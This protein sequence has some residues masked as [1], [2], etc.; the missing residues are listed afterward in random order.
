MKNPNK[1]LEAFLLIMALKDRGGSISHAIAKCIEEKHE[2]V[3]LE[4][5]EN[6]S[7]GKLLS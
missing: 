2:F 1:H 5:Q 3:L 6:V 4:F 7:F